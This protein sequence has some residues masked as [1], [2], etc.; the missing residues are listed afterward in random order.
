MGTADFYAVVEGLEEIV[1]SL[2]VDTTELG[3]ADE[4]ELLC[5]VVLA[6][7]ATLAEVEPRLRQ[8]LARS[9]AAA[10]AGPVPR[11]RCD[12]AHAQR[13]E[14]RGTGEADPRRGRPGPGREPGGVGQPGF[15]GPFIQLAR[16]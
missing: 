12:P 4:G 10:R 8:A 11:R 9:V 2:V 6:P 3:A 16:H 7:G 1:D 14:V 15:A 5:F 13:Q